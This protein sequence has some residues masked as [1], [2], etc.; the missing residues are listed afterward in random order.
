[1]S[2]AAGKGAKEKLWS[3]RFITGTLAN[4]TVLVNHYLLMVVMTGYA[5]VKFSAPEP[6]AAFCASVFVVGALFSRIWSGVSMERIGRKKLLVIGAVGEIVFS[7]LYVVVDLLPEMLVLRF[8]HGFAFGMC[9]TALATI[10]A[11]IV[12]A[13][14]KGE[15]IG[16]FMLSVTLGAAIGPFIG[17]FVSNNFGYD[18]LFVIAFVSALL[19]LAGALLLKVPSAP[20]A[21]IQQEERNDL[22]EEA[23][24]ASAVD[25]PEDPLRLERE[26]E[27][28]KRQHADFQKSAARAAA[29]GDA[30]AAGVEIRD[31]EAAAAGAS[32]AENGKGNGAARLEKDEAP[33]A[34]GSAARKGSWISRVFEPQVLPISLVAFIVFFTYSSLMTFLTPYSQEIGLSRSA[35]V[36]FVSY[37]IVTFVTRPFTGTAF[38]RKGP[39]FVMVPAFFALAAG[40][41]MLGAAQN[42]WI[43][44]LSSMFL[45]YG[46]GTIQ[47]SGL[48]MA[49]RRVP[50]ER[51]SKANST[52][53]V[54]LDAGVGIG[55]VFL[56]MLVPMIGYRA[57]YELMAA[58][59]LVGLVVFLVVCRKDLAAGE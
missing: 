34:A 24:L 47:S 58:V 8:V 53:Y 18:V 48:A 30:P 35:S 19:T 23:A 51:L 2:P 59:A 10:V 12:P 4:F 55:P 25:A 37:A 9:S 45:G 15:G 14:R 32:R 40:M 26:S 11:A 44:L 31:A 6:V 16:Y 22:V 27:E 33:S 36:F 39:R 20:A 28:A 1:M 56:G 17:I 50:D 52:F 13:S 41:A 3:G 49:V 29:C 7:A 43:L 57:M 54:M 46:V 38:D 5:L 42:D 21:A